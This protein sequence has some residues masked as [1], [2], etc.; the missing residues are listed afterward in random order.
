MARPIKYGLDYWS[1]DVDIFDDEKI[2]PISGEFGIKGQIALIHLLCAIYRNGYFIL[3]TD[4]LKYTLC[5]KM[6]GINE[7]LLEMIVIRLVKWGFFDENLFSSVKVLTSKAIQERYFSAVYRRKIIETDEF[8]LVPLPE[9]FCCQKQAGKSGKEGF[10]QHNDNNN[11][12][13]GGFLLS[14]THKGNKRKEIKEI[15]PDGD[16]KKVPEGLSSPSAHKSVFP[17]EKIVG[18]W[19]TTCTGY[20]KLT[21][22]SEKRKMKLKNRIEEISKMGEPLPLFQ[23]L[24]EKMQN[25]SFLKGDNRRGWKATFDWLI[26][27]GE[28]WRKVLEGNYDNEFMSNDG[29]YY[30]TGRNRAEECKVSSRKP[31][32]CSE[33]SVRIPT[34]TDYPSTL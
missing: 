9:G 30:D 6:P 15:S 14:K 18:M 24:F 12:P 33:K 26:S 22:L 32:E 3:W 17:Y 23:T 5:S 34:E 29:S 28:N 13:A 8:L 10:C 20:H 7:E 2:R 25:S 27:N 11:T 1:C 4:R 21:G 16:T 19:N 31:G